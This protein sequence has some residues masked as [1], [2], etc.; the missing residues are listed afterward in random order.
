MEG[1]LAELESDR[2]PEAGPSTSSSV[3]SEQIIATL[4]ACGLHKK[5]FVGI[6]P[7]LAI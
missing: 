3:I 1:V 5:L 7:M 6:R 2:R 4:N